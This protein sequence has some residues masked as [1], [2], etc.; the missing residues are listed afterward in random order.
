[1]CS[2]KDI[3]HWITHSPTHAPRFAASRFVSAGPPWKPK[4]VLSVVSPVHG[5]I[6]QRLSRRTRECAMIPETRTSEYRDDDR[7]RGTGCSGNVPKDVT[8]WRIAVRCPQAD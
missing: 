1:M 3:G 2:G 5:D 7:I 4:T 8:S 6:T